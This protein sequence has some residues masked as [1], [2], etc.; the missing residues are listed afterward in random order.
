MKAGI[1]TSGSTC[2]GS[3]Y[4]TLC[5]LCPLLEKLNGHQLPWATTPN[6]SAI[7]KQDSEHLEIDPKFLSI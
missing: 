1:E 6:T 2:Q 3:S 5:T 7:M 4:Y